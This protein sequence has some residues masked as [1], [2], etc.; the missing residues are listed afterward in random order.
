M[1]DFYAAAARVAKAARE[2]IFDALGGVEVTEEEYRFACSTAWDG[3]TDQLVSLPQKVR[4]AEREAQAPAGSRAAAAVAA[5]GFEFGP[6]TDESKAAMVA[7]I[8]R[9]RS[10]S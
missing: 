9:N 10:A 8:R 6:V 1:I 5:T 7:S 4:E 2:R 3:G